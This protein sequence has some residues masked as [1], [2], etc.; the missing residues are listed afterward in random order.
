MSLSMDNDV[1]LN[2]IELK[3]ASGVYDKDDEMLL[4]LENEYEEINRRR[5]IC[6]DLHDTLLDIE[7]GKC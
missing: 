5:E 4:E 7:Y 3:L 6:A 2:Q 1:K